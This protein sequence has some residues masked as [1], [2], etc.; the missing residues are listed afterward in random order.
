MPLPQPPPNPQG[1][2]GS[3]HGQQAS[4]PNPNRR[5]NRQPG[6]HREASVNSANL[7]R[8]HHEPAAGGS[9]NNN[10]QE[11]QPGH[12]RHR[13]ASRVGEPAPLPAQPAAGPRSNVDGRL[14]ALGPQAGDDARY[15]I[16]ALAA[17]R[18]LEEENIAGHSCFGPR[19][20]QEPFPKGFTLP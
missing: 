7:A 14:G 2:G 3:R 15:R 17:S 16:D 1:T 6:G 19:I 5:A 12:Y 4:S 13:P 10:N 11:P 9:R 8:R 20:R 18:A